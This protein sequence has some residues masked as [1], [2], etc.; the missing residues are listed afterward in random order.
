MCILVKDKHSVHK[1][2]TK[3]LQSEKPKNK[4]I[5]HTKDVALDHI[6]FMTALQNILSVSIT[7]EFVNM[8]KCVKHIETTKMFMN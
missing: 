6:H 3:I 4:I 7:K 2:K 1:S 8:L 5:Q